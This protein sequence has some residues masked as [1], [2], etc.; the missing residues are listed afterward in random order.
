MGISAVVSAAGMLVV[1]N[2]VLFPETSGSIVPTGETLDLLRSD[3]EAAWNAFE[4]Q[5]APVEPLRGFVATAGLALW[6]AAVLAD[7]AAFRLRSVPETITPATTIFVFTVLLGDGSHPV[8][9]AAL[10][11]AVVGAVILSLR[12][13]RQAATTC[14]SPP[15]PRL[16]SRPRCGRAW[17]ARHRPLGRRSGRAG[18]ARCGEQLLDPSEWDNG[19]ETRRVTSPL[20][21]ISASLLDQ[22]ER[23]LFSVGV[24]DPMDRHYWRQMALTEFN[25]REWRRSSSFDDANGRVPS[26]IA[27]TVNRTAVRQEIT[28]TALGGIYLPAAYEISNVLTSGDVELEYEVETGRW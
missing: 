26:N 8:I 21:E 5:Q 1:G 28:T 20:V 17:S 11:V 16:D 25:G 24:D 18:T 19:P 7:W 27:S 4:L 3:L 13:S 14:G 10:F 22:T 2:I 6:W 15:A 9:H 23:E 12:L